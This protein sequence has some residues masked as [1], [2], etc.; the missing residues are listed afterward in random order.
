MSEPAAASPH[1]ASRRAGVRTS[2]FLVALAAWAVP[3]S[4]YLL[5]GQWA[6][7]ITAGL[8]ILLT[9]V[10]GIFIGGVRV[11]D[12]PG[13]A[14]GGRK[15]MLV[16]EDSAAPRW[17]LIARPMRTILEKPWYIGQI[18]SGPVA[19]IASHYS[20]EAARSQIPKGTAHVAEFGT[21]YCA[22][23]GMLNLLIIIDSSAR[24]AGPR[25]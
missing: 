6:R 16:P 3:G 25:P 5:I 8:T 11:V 1:A 4:G 7:G 17:A 21:L 9:F 20:L 2:P 12:V 10:A 15:V 18:L 19:L 23:A 13:Y 14:E 24:A 22:I